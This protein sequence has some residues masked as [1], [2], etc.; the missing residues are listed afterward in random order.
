[1]G[2]WAGAFGKIKGAA[3]RSLRMPAPPFS[4]ARIRAV[5]PSARSVS[6][7]A[8]RDDS[9][10]EVTRLH[11]VRLGDEL[12]RRGWAHVDLLSLDV[13]RARSRITIPTTSD[14]ISPLPPTPSLPPMLH[15]KEGHE[16]ETLLGVDFTRVHIDFILSES[17]QVEVLLRPLGYEPSR[18]KFGGGDVLWARPGHAAAV[19]QA[20]IAR[21]IK[22]H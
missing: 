11:C 21:G 14:C 1:M 4:H 15:S 22:L 17:P 8:L 7:K 16:L 5:D 2:D 13:V 10:G 19:L 18:L 3:V 6:Q 20:A 12:L 9:S